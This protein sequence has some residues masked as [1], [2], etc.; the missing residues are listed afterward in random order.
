[1][2]AE[3]LFIKDTIS[4]SRHAAPHT[5]IILGGAYY[6]R[7]SSFEVLRPDFGVIDESEVPIKELL[8]AIEHGNQLK[9][10]KI[11]HIGKRCCYL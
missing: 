6:E 2:V 10:L 3:Y 1:M 11:L 8:N 5:P 7:P 4:A 9:T